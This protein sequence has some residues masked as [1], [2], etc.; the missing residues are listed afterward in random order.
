MYFNYRFSRKHFYELGQVSKSSKQISLEFKTSLNSLRPS[1]S[2]LRSKQNE[3]KRNGVTKLR[4]Q[5]VTH[6]Y[7]TFYL[8]QIGKL[9]QTE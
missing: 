7:Y 3:E 4:G 2:E 9:L 5:A 6:S 1:L 8:I